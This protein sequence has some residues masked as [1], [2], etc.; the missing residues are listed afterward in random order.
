M[1]VQLFAKAKELAGGRNFILC[2][3]AGGD[4][5]I[6]CQDFLDRY[7]FQVP[8]SDAMTL[9]ASHAAPFGAAACASSLHVMLREPTTHQCYRC[10]SLVGGTC[11]CGAEGY[12]VPCGER[13]VRRV[14]GHPLFEGLRPPF[15]RPIQAAL[16]RLAAVDRYL[17][18][19]TGDVALSGCGTCVSPSRARARAYL[20]VN[21][22]PR[23]CTGDGR[24]RS[25]T[26]DQ[27]RL[28]QHPSKSFLCALEGMAAPHVEVGPTAKPCH[29]C[30][31]L[32][33]CR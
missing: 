9:L 3:I 21:H 6:V 13:R 15:S 2:A 24:R 26:T 33:V 28:A 14:F 12:C 5:D 7:V 17:L 18:C 29:V 32:R 22:S 8:P 1:K 16:G 27:R 4:E 20:C 19:K 11:A 31:R 30:P 23:I 25:H 10:V